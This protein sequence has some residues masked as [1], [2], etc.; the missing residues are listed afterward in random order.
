MLQHYLIAN[1]W[2]NLAAT[3][4]MI[5][6]EPGNAVLKVMTPYELEEAQKLSSE[7]NG[8]INNQH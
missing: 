4:L 3:K 8:I 2:T 6:A 7:P 5:S 1:T